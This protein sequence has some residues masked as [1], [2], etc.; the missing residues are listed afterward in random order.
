[1]THAVEL[2]TELI[3]K[4]DFLVERFSKVEDA[5]IQASKKIGVLSSCNEKMV[6]DI[7]VL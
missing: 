1:M 2:L 3:Q 6:N 7:A 4:F 5:Y